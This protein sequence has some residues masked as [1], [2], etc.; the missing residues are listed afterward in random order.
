MRCKTHRNS[1]SAALFRNLCHHL[2]Q[3]HTSFSLSRPSSTHRPLS[4]VVHGSNY[5]TH[6]FLVLITDTLLGTCRHINLI[7]TATP[8]TTLYISP[9]LPSLM[10]IITWLGLHPTS[11]H[12]VLY[13]PPPAGKPNFIE[14]GQANGFGFTQSTY[15]KLHCLANL[16]IMLAWQITGNSKMT[17]DM[18]AHAIHCLVT[19]ADPQI[20][21]LSGLVT[22]LYIH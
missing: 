4:D 12:R 7:I 10:E 18:N 11:V 20:K 8:Y 5:Q 1:L 3:T 14:G 13:F 6:A 21:A 22:N 19:V 9:Y 17:H 16:R 15:H 2:L